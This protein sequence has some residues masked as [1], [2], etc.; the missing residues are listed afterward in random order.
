MNFYPLL[1]AFE[2]H[3]MGHPHKLPLGKV[4]CK[5]MAGERP[6]DDD[7]SVIVQ[8]FVGQPYLDTMDLQEVIDSIN[9]VHGTAYTITGR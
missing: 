7:M 6:N 3:G 2:C 5:L 8:A 4:M 1:S 9:E